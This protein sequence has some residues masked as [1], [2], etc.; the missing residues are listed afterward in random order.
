MKGKNVLWRWLSV[1]S[2]LLTIA[3]NGY[4]STGKINGTTTAEVSDSF[5]VL[6]VPAG[7]IF[8]IWGVIYLL[9]IA[10]L[11]YQFTTAQKDDPRFLA[12]APYFVLSN[13]AN[14]LW[15]ILFHY[16]VH[17]FTILP[18]LLLLICLIQIYLKLQEKRG[19]GKAYYFMDLPFSIYLGWISV[20]TIANMTQFLDF[21]GFS[22]WGIAPEIWLTIVLLVAVL[23]SWVMSRKF[24]DLAYVLVLIWA[25]IGIGVRF[26]ANG[27]VMISSFTAAG[28]VLLIFLF[29]KKAGN[30]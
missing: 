10:F 15:L 26:L 8:S 1:V 12:I 21:I 29:T 7:Y 4:A 9:L 19:K 20:A 14:G 16:Q 18:M 25:F 11:I 24:H 27:I 3:V 28:F 22:G 23:L 13:L 30:R 2:F 6:F 17:A 5:D